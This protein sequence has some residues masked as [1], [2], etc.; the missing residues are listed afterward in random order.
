MN[1]DLLDR[2]GDFDLPTDRVW[3]NA[4]HQGPL[5]TR[6][7]DAVAEMVHWKQQ[8]HHMMTPAPF[9]DVPERLRSA[10]AGLLAVSPDELALANSSSYG[11]HLV[12][13]GFEFR[14]GD[15]VM[16]AGNDFPS[17]ILPFTR[18]VGRGVVTKQ[19]KPAAQV[20]T[21]AEV[22]AEITPRTRLVCLTW[23]HSLSGQVIDLDG[24][25]E[26]CRSHDVLFVVN[27]SQGI[28]GIPLRPGDHP[29]DV[30]TS[31]G[32]KYL[33]GPYGTGF[34]W[35]SARAMERIE[36]SKLYWL[37]A[38][39]ADD[40]AADSLDLGSIGVSPSARRHDVFGT[41]NFFNFAALAASVELVCEI[42][43][44]RIHAHNMALSER[45]VA[46]ID[47]RRHAVQDRGTPTRRS[48]VLF[49]RPVGRTLDEAAA[50]L[51]DARIDV[52]RRR[53]MIRVAPHFYNDHADIDR[54]VK[55]LNNG[56]AKEFPT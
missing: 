15:E 49:L 32:F 26:V 1:L 6:A 3:L 34:C 31:V 18:L 24:I 33:C 39:T 12:A 20:L 14:P 43:V 52:S 27:G 40:L 7:A 28:G 2:R 51:A 23:V 54:A 56:P 19:L 37:S 44:E 5:P 36:T 47:P 46:E 55:V 21:P 30:L 38:L 42:G 11:L 25:G 45:L 29:I 53:G 8:P 41:A 48:A 50:E 16:V 13:N 4:S 10:L 35:L 17:D 9:T 22:A